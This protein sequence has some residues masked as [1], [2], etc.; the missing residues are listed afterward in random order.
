MASESSHLS[1]TQWLSPFPPSLPWSISA[2]YTSLLCYPSSILSSPSSGTRPLPNPSSNLKGR[3]DSERDPTY[4]DCT[5]TMAERA[6]THFCGI[7]TDAAASMTEDFQFTS[8]IEQYFGHDPTPFA[9]PPAAMIEDFQFEN[10]LTPLT[11][12]WGPT[13]SSSLQPMTF[14][15]EPLPN[16]TD[17]LGPNS[18]T[19]AQ[20]PAA[21]VEDFQFDNASTPLTD[22]W[23]STFP[24]ASHVQEL[25]PREQ[26]PP[27]LPEVPPL[28]PATGPT[29][30]TASPTTSLGE[31]SEPDWKLLVPRI[32]QVIFKRLHVSKSAVTRYIDPSIKEGSI[33]WETVWEYVQ[34]HEMNVL[35]KV[36]TSKKL[37][38]KVSSLYSVI[39]LLPF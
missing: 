3:R 30:T 15:P 9:Q 36:F 8:G 6:P 10:W 35:R 38:Q 17:A 34:C 31:D 29:S 5:T 26:V 1:S 32:Q 23:P 14:F 20:P 2:I 25:L 16:I 4:S 13:F 33:K 37:W 22:P 27:Y 39:H 19:F 12:P 24:S 18:N 28:A 21:M 7:L 11:D